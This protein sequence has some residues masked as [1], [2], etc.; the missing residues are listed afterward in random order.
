MKWL[1][2]KLAKRPAW[3]RLIDIVSK[4]QQMLWCM[5]DQKLV[6]SL[7]L[8]QS[9]SNHEQLYKVEQKHTAV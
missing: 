4:D 6:T 3:M 1:L 7:V 5:S 2:T 8:G 9:L